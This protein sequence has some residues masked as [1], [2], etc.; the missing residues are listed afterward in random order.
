MYDVTSIQMRL[1]EEQE[2][3]GTAQLFPPTAPKASKVEAA[4]MCKSTSA[5]AA[6]SSGTLEV[7]VDPGRTFHCRA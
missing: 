2:V 5:N 1:D 3:P 6:S 4:D 7:G